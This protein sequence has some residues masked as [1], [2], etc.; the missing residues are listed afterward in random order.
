MIPQIILYI[1]D[2]NNPVISYEPDSSR[3]LINAYFYKENFDHKY[4]Y[5]YWQSFDETHKKNIILLTKFR[6]GLI[7]ISRKE[8]NNELKRREIKGDISEGTESFKGFDDAIKAYSNMYKGDSLSL[9][10]FIP[11]LMD[12]FSLIRT[13]GF[14]FDNDEEK[15]RDVSLFT[16]TMGNLIKQFLEKIVYIGPLRETPRRHY[17]YRGI[18]FEE[19]GSGGEMVPDVLFNNP[20]LIE[21]I[22]KEFSRFGINYNFK[23]SPFWNDQTNICEVFSIDLIEKFTG[24]SAS[25]RDVGFGISQVL[26]I[27]MQ[28][29]LSV[30]GNI[31][32][33]QPELH[34]H[35]A[36]QAELGDL[37]IDSALGEQKNTFIIETHSEHLILRILRRIRETSEGE[38]PDGIQKIFPNDVA[39]IYAQ[40]TREG[41]RIVH[42]P[43]TED[44]EFEIPWPEGFFTERAKELF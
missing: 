15:S 3:K 30:K 12:Y 14:N 44:G 33:E 20:D 39:I 28:S 42:V 37:F 13:I 43:I 24:N 1:G 5:T 38:L 2:N 41:S 7:N 8:T 40:P 25:I 35:P 27:I 16:L 22:N 34:L 31:L 9:V 4:W 6:D 21:K 23:L 19:V 18:P 26:P 17:I 11:A 32:I 10:C 36:L 29:L